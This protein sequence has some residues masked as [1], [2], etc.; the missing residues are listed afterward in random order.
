MPRQHQQRHGTIYHAL[1]ELLEQ[2]VC[3][4]GRGDLREEDRSRGHRHAQQPVADLRVHAGQ[5]HDALFKPIQRV[6]REL[7][8]EGVRTHGCAAYLEPVH[9]DLEVRRKAL[10]EQERVQIVRL[11]VGPER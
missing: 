6:R 2:T 5:G 10:G 7:A 9:Y 3:E 4:E 11:P 1:V 8:D